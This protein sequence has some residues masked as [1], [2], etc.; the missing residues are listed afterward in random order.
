GSPRDPEKLDPIAELARELDVE[1]GDVADAFDMHRVQRDPR[2]EGDAGE[3][4]EL[5]RRIDAVDV[6]ARVRFRVAK[7]LCLEQDIVEVAAGL[8]PCGENVIAGAVEDPIDA[9]E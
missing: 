3:D 5:M 9:I 4:C 7:R 1:R 8:P 6:E 2:P